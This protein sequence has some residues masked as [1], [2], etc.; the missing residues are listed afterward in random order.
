MVDE[1]SLDSKQEMS[2][3]KSSATLHYSELK[4]NEKNTMLSDSS[5]EKKKIDENE[6]QRMSFSGNQIDL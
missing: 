3:S 4:E 1:G 6:Y 2:K 5:H